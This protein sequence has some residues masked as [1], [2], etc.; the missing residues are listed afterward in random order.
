MDK[1]VFLDKDGVI[2]IDE[3]L[4]KSTTDPSIYPYVGDT[5]ACLNRKGYKVFIVTNQSIV[6]R[7]LITISQMAD[8]FMEL[9]RN[10]LRQNIDASIKDIYYCPHHPNADVPKYKKNCDCRKPHSGLLLQAAIDYNI[11]LS[12]SYMVGDRISDVIA[13]QNAGCKTITIMTGKHNDK[14]TETDYKVPDGTVGISPD[15][16]VYEIEALQGVIR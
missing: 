5:I 7:G 10:I 15:W 4:P 1:A 2:N 11:D 13:G 8:Y 3:G 14:C 12:K 16:S 6:A 9:E